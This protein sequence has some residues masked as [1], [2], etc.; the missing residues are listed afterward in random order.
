MNRRDFIK[1]LGT[2]ASIVLLPIGGAEALPEDIPQQA[3]DSLISGLPAF[4]AIDGINLWGTAL[5]SRVAHFSLYR[6]EN[7]IIRLSLNV[8]GG[9]LIWRAGHGDAIVETSAHP[10]R[11]DCPDLDVDY[12][13]VADTGARRNVR[14]RIR[15]F[16][17]NLSSDA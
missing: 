4:L 9:T 3:P 11:I 14:G 12:T 10:V 16:A 8:W 17:Y 15:G 13:V 7:L 1:L 2:T 5:E 6:Q